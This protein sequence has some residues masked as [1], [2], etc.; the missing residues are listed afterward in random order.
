MEKLHFLPDIKHRIHTGFWVSQSRYK[1]EYE[2]AMRFSID[3]ILPQYEAYYER[4]RS[5]ALIG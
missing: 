5:E 3:T 1:Q 2:Q 4:I